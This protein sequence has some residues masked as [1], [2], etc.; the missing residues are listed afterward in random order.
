MPNQWVRWDAVQPLSDHPVGYFPEQVWI[1]RESIN[2]VSVSIATASM[3]LYLFLQGYNR[4]LRRMGVK[5]FFIP[6]ALLVVI[7]TTFFSWLRE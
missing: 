5:D 6:E 2:W 4:Y 1:C 3:V 7:I